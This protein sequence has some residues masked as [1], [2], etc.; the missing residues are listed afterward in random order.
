MRKMTEAAMDLRNNIDELKELVFG[1]CMSWK[2][3]KNLSSIDLDAMKKAD[4]ILENTLALMERHSEAMV[5]IEG[6]LDQVLRRLDE[7]A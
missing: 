4:E 5:R 6:K 1:N 3:I 7:R 2:S